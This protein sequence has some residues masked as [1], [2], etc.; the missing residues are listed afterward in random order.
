V[1]VVGSGIAGLSVALRLAAEHGCGSIAV[2]CKSGFGDGASRWAQGGIACALGGDDSP[3]LHA[4]DTLAVSGEL[5]E[6]EIVRILTQAAP[7]RLVRLIERGTRFDRDAGGRLD[8][9]LE[10]G[11]GR[12]RILHA[13]GD[14]TGAEIMRALTAAAAARPAIRVHEQMRATDLIV[15]DGRVVGISARDAHGVERVFRS[16]AVV[17]ATGGFGHAYLKTTNPAE[18]TG[19]ALAMAARAGAALIDMEFVQFHPTALDVAGADPMPLLTEALRGAGALLVDGEGRRFM[20]KVSRQA[21]LA[22][23]DLVARTLWERLAAGERVFLDCRPA[24]E[25]RGFPTAVAACRRYGLD[26]AAAPVPISPAAHYTMGGIAVDGW[27]RSSLPGLW[28][29][30]EAAGSGVHGANRLASNSLLEGL[31]FGARVADD[32]AR[33]PF[34]AKP[35]VE[36][37]SASSPAGSLGC[38]GEIVERVRRLLWERVGVVR[39]ELGLQAALRELN[40]LESRAAVGTAGRDLITVGKLVATAALARRESRGAHYRRD[41]PHSSERWRRRLTVA[42]GPPVESTAATGETPSGALPRRAWS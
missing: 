39:T 13:N 30:G 27:G 36:S 17:L 18:A 23:R 33:R 3:A 24:L 14:A 40:R 28:A 12:R 22:P 6:P 35:P 34:P 37:P 26:P 21:E 31:V 42:L 25:H 38:E 41:F 15:V 19:D 1:V 5:G 8:L 4:A 2:I 9:G 16:A 7:E 10:G 29:C 32:L 11:H 20:T